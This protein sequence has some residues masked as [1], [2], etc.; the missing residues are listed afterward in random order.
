LEEVAGSEREL[1][2]PQS[3]TVSPIRDEDLSALADLE[4]NR[5]TSNLRVIFGED[6]I[7]Y[8]VES[9]G[10]ELVDDDTET[11]LAYLR[12]DE[13]RIGRSGPRKGNGRFRSPRGERG[14]GVF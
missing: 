1:P 13:R 11:V 12:E 5:K 14:I 3:S 8:I 6:D 9:S 10:L 7:P 4:A 2:L